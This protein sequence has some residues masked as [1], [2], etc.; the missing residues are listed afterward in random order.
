MSSNLLVVVLRPS[1]RSRLLNSSR[2]Q[3]TL[4]P[5]D[6][7]CRARVTYVPPRL[8]HSADNVSTNKSSSDVANFFQ[9]TT[10]Q[11]HTA[12]HKHDPTSGTKM[13]RAGTPVY[14]FIAIFNE[15]VTQQFMSVLSSLRSSHYCQS[16]QYRLSSLVRVDSTHLNIGKSSAVTSIYGRTIGQQKGW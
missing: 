5:H 6:A 2:R 1:S 11:I 14:S 8:Q 7:R 13:S 15:T 12:R 10:I 4:T 3:T 9:I 16:M